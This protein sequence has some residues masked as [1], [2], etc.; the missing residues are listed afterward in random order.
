MSKIN[1]I[2]VIIHIYY[3]S[4]FTLN[5]LKVIKLYL[6]IQKYWFFFYYF[7]LPTSR[8]KS[9]LPPQRFEDQFTFLG[10][11]HPLNPPLTKC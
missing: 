3:P 4:L 5:K 7:K 8:L 2:Q 10:Q 11:C 1:V 6:Y 9:V